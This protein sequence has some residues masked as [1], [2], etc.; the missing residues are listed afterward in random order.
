MTGI[1]Y[2]CG[3]LDMVTELRMEMDG[4]MRDGEVDM[5]LEIHQRVL[6]RLIKDEME[7]MGKEIF[8]EEYKKQTDA[9]EEKKAQMKSKI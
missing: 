2:W 8:P 9:S 1:D 4:L 7:N 5:F 6:E 3:K